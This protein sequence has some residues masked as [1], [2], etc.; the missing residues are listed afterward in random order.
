MVTKLINKNSDYIEELKK[1]AF[2]F[3]AS[4][5]VPKNSTPNDCF[6]YL[7]D[8]LIDGMPCDRVNELIES[9]EHKLIWRQNICVHSSYWTEVGG[10]VDVYY[11]LRHEIIK[12]ML[13]KSEFE[14]IS[15]ETGVNTIRR[16]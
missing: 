2:S 10:N 3:G 7:N 9:D 11:T 15:N 5:S 16:K 8:S 12:G 6:K 4:H 14:F 13:S 1:I